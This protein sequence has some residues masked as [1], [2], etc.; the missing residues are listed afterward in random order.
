M[1]NMMKVVFMGLFLA[2]F[3][4]VCPESNAQF[5]KFKKNKAKKGDVT[6][7]P[8]F[9]KQSKYDKL[10]KNA[11]VKKGMFNI[12]RK[13]GKIYFEIPKNLFKNDFLLTS[14]V[15]K[16]STNENCSAGQIPREPVLIHFSADTNKLYVHKPII[17]RRCDKNSPIYKSFKR[18][19]IDPIWLAYEIKAFNSDSSALV[20]DVT[21]LFLGSTKELLPFA[22]PVTLSQFFKPFNGPMDRNRSKILECKSF[23][24]NV[25]INS[26]MTHTVNKIIL[27]AELSRNI[28]KL[29]EN[30]MSMRYCDDRLGYFEGR[31]EKF[32]TDGASMKRFIHRW[33]IEPKKEDIEK[34][35]RGELVEP[36]KPIVWYVDTQIPAKWREYV[37][38]GIEDWQLAFEEIGFKNAI[39][40]KDYPTKEEDPNFDPDN[41]KYSCYRY[42][43]T[44]VKNSMGP[45]WIDPRSG[46][47]ITGD[48]LFFSNVV[49]LL[50]EWRFIQTAQVDERVRTKKMNDKLIGES[51]RN[52]AAHEVG[53]TLGLMHNFIASTTY[54]VDSL[55][56]AKFTKE[57]GT[58]PSIM[59]YARYN[60]VAQPQDKGV[61]LTPPKVGIY[62]KFQIKLGYKYVSKATT[63][64]E[65]F[66][67][68][69]KWL[70]EKKDDMRYTYVNP[71]VHPFVPDHI[72]PA[73]NTESLG[74]DLVKANSYGIKNLKLIEKNL[75][76]WLL[77]EGDDYNT[78]REYHIGV[79][80]Q[81]M[82]YLAH[83][84]AL[85]GGEY[86]IPTYVGYNIKSQKF[87]PRK[88]QKEA[89]NFILK[90]LK[91]FPNWWNN[92]DV[93]KY[94][95]RMADCYDVQAT[96]FS[97]LFNAKTAAFL[98]KQ[99]AMQIKDV[100]TFNEYHSD[101]Y[102][103]VWK[104][105]LRNRKL[106][107]T[108]KAFQSMYVNTLVGAM[109]AGGA[110]INKGPAALTQFNFTEE[111]KSAM[112]SM[113]G[114]I[115]SAVNYPV[116]GSMAK[117]T[118]RLLRKM[119]SASKGSD[120]LHYESLYY[121][122]NK[123]MKD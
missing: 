68:V 103:N 83:V 17:E 80:K 36:S 26:L 53:H 22:P 48:V 5:W 45:S 2:L 110:T 65:D 30:P 77:E 90:E 93:E 99:E 75:T 56:S 67:E 58:T 82:M 39:I 32:N 123:A 76:K 42:I 3:L 46:E 49:K 109:G 73:N 115:S 44:S 4:G 6:K 91:N 41:I 69:K 60:Y 86:R 52:V 71:Y 18:N 8:E 13:E 35:N 96:I 89:I 64:E 116:I 54:P 1:N 63:P 106:N 78:L 61:F 9:K 97:A 111:Q 38:K 7:A 84:Y 114:S 102:N 11:D 34:Y 33:R 104:N 43:P 72:N 51:L 14:R 59:D 95:G 121:K 24:E 57:Y 70:F 40:A 79:G 12:I 31:F 87:V 55:R 117:K 101:I 120:K 118:L 108:D 88:K 21:N 113:S 92:K 81:F 10:I 66:S 107:L 23:E 98:I 19:N 27:T 20:V 122:L 119:K 94:L 16:I 50:Q 100:Y 47:I 29:P 15:T 28:I 112:I 105:S 62:D 74:D 85:V 37:K 25:Q